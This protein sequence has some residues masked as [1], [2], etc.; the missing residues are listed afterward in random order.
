MTDENEIETEELETEEVEAEETPERPESAEETAR[1]VW[2]ELSAKAETEE[3]EKP[4]D[5]APPAEEKP[6]DLSDAAR[7]LASAKKFKKRQTFVPADTKQA[8]EAAPAERYE[9][10][11]GFPVEDKEW[12]L[13][14][15]PVVQ[16]NVS[17]WFKNVQGK[18]TKVWQDLQRETATAKEINQVIDRHWKDLDLPAHFSRAQVIDEFFR[19]QKEINGDSEGAILKMMDHRGVTLEK[20]AARLNGQTQAPARQQQAQ[21]PQKEYLTAEEFDR[22]LEAKNAEQ[23]QQR[24]IESATDEVRQLQR[25]MHDGRFKW[26]ELHSK[27]GIDRIQHL[28]TYFRE[29]NPTLTWKD[30]YSKALTQDR[31]NRGVA[32]P[33]PTSQRLTPNDIQTVRQASSSLRSRGG[34]G[35]IPR[36]AEPK[37][38]E[39]ARESAEAAYYEVFG[40]KQH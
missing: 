10:P 34:N 37:S 8:A 29:N 3:G 18:T 32:T 17:T 24:A 7:K 38:T 6:S 1:A 13:K 2:E 11:Q 15:P 33:S 23:N 25:E 22:R 27:E 14:Q 20:L 21:Q 40:N 9:P 12:F 4:A 31:Q 35:A 5:A 28:V 36:M 30:W 39:T 16:K 26:P 19:Y